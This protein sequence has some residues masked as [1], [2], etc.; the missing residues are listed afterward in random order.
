M[1]YAG[2]PIAEAITEGWQVLVF[3]WNRRDMRCI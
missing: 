3:Q 1:I 2:V